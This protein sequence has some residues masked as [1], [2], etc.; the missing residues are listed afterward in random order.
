MSAIDG[1][2]HKPFEFVD[3][4]ATPAPAH[5]SAGKDSIR[6]KQAGH[7]RHRTPCS[8]RRH[9]SRRTDEENPEAKQNK[10]TKKAKATERLRQSK[11]QNLMDYP[12]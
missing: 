10:A 8:P 12:T 6:D 4:R 5:E 11:A 9:K 3:F 7:S 1:N 2:L